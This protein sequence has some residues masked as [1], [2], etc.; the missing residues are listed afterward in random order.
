MHLFRRFISIFAA[1]AVL[2]AL[3]ATVVRA[4]WPTTCV[5]LNDQSEAAPWQLSE[6]RDLPACLRRSSRS[7]L[8]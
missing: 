4:Q 3:A 8:S 2:T 7:R 5:D 1:V 6:R